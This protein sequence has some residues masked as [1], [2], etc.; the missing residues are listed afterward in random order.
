MLAGILH[1]VD[2]VTLTTNSRRRSRP[3]QAVLVADLAGPFLQRG[4]TLRLRALHDHAPY[5]LSS[6]QRVVF[7]FTRNWV[8]DVQ[9]IK[10]HHIT[11]GFFSYTQE[12]L[13]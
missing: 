4:H 9:G 1:T 2:P 10:D 5:T 6:L 13:S 3:D 8:C 7:T 12:K 11:N